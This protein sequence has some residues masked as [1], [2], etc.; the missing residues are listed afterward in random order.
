MTWESALTTPHPRGAY[1]R[2]EAAG[3]DGLLLVAPY[4]SLPAQAGVIRHILTVADVTEL[5]VMLNDART[6]I[7]MHAA[8]HRRDVCASQCPCG[9]G[10][11]GDLFEAMSIVDWTPL[12]YYCDIDE[13]N[14]AYLACGAT[15]VLSVVGNFAADRIA[16]R[17][18]AVR[19]GDLES[20]RRIQTS[21]IGIMD[22]VVRTSQGGIMLEAAP[23]G[24]GII[25]HPAVRLS[26]RGITARRSGRAQ[27]CTRRA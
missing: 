8:H 15:G 27:R 5:P 21:L 19:T 13:L 16:A 12:A 2:P 20:A 7:P 1:D 11:R 22:A 10:R 26:A 3:A 6:G 23:A 14:L 24:L 4:Y 25:T 18:A 9:Q 17:I